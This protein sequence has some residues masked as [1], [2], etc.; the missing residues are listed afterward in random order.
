MAIL[1]GRY[2]KILFD[3]TGAI[4]GTPVAIIAV[5]TWK[6]DFKTDYEDV[7]CF[8][9][10]NKVY[11]PGL[12]DVSGTLGGFWD[13]D[14][15]TLFEAADATTPGTLQL[16]PNDTE[17]TF[18]WEGLAYMDASIDCSLTAPKVTGNFRAA[19]PWTG[20]THP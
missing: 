2:G 3:P 6:A 16:M 9:D 18:F 1:T 11:V 8:G 14:E 17:P 13:K 15:V 5:N 20:P 12:K 10:T 7:T 4:P 19:G